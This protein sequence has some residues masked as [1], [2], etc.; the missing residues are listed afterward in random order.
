MY[1]FSMYILPHVMLSLDTIYCAAMT[2]CNRCSFFPFC[3]RCPCSDGLDRINSRVGRLFISTFFFPI[4]SLFVLSHSHSP[5]LLFSILPIPSFPMVTQSL[6]LSLLGISKGRWGLVGVNTALMGA[7]YF[8]A[9]K[10]F[11]FS[12][13]YDWFLT[14]SHAFVQ[15]YHYFIF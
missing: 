7:Q 9:K 11:V 6:S 10:P 1:I 5:S 3:E 8:T 12:L 13:A 2:P 14:I 15:L 4:F